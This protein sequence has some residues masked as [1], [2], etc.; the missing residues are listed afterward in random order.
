MEKAVVLAGNCLSLARVHIETGLVDPAKNLTMCLKKQ[1]RINI[2]LQFFTQP[3]FQAVLP[4]LNNNRPKCEAFLDYILATHNK[5]L[6][7]LSTLIKKYRPHLI[8]VLTGTYALE[9]EK[10]L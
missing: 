3:A 8:T 1:S 7:L 6:P 9:K 2:V 4:R 10:D 5:A